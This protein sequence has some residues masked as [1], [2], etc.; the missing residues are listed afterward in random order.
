MPPSLRSIKVAS[1]ITRSKSELD[2]QHLRARLLSNAR[3]G[4]WFGWANRSNIDYSAWKSM[5]LIF[6]PSS[7]DGDCTA[8]S[9]VFC[10]PAAGPTQVSHDSTG[11][12]CWR[13]SPVQ[14]PK[15]RVGDLS[16]RPTKLHLRSQ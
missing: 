16:V 7:I 11:Y 15:K 10:Y 3:R 1:E 8:R 5:C 14:N 12:S 9:R 6:N 4:S 13:E 2:G